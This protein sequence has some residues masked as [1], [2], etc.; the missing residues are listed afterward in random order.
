MNVTMQ[1]NVFGRTKKESNP[2]PDPPPNSHMVRVQQSNFG[3][4]L[5]T[6][7]QPT[8]SRE[9][10]KPN[11]CPSSAPGYALGR[12][13]AQERWSLLHRLHQ[14]KP[15]LTTNGWVDI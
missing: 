3:F 13:R 15:L 10:T 8:R 11:A 12:R 6:V 5:G 14:R 9:Q 7:L 1:D 2:L 4:F